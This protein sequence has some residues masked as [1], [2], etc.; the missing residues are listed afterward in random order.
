MFRIRSVIDNQFFSTY[1]I[2]TSI[3]FL[4]PILSR[5]RKS[6]SFL[7]LACNCGSVSRE[8][9]A[10]CRNGPAESPEVQQREMQSP[11]SAV[12]HMHQERLGS[13]QLEGSP[14]ENDF[15]SWW[16]TNQSQNSNTSLEAKVSNSTQQKSIT[17]T[18][19][20][21]IFPLFHLNNNNLY[22]LPRLSRV[23]LSQSAACTSFRMQKLDH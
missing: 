20:E 4:S 18:P 8:T 1:P 6:V 7:G 23:V 3:N 11:S 21:M 14:G 2:H 15:R 19:G 22:S 9:W 5:R 12:E 10:G 16:T 17:T 13:N